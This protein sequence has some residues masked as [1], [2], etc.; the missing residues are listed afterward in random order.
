MGI[1]IG[2]KVH[3]AVTAESLPLSIAVGPGMTVKG[4]LKF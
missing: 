1:S 3:A 2:C 4:S